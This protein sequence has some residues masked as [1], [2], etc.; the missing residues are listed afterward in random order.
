MPERSS[1]ATRRNVS[2]IIGNLT[3]VDGRGTD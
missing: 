1:P 3:E 2:R